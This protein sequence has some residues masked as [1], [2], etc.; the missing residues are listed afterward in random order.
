M[1]KIKSETNVDIVFKSFEQ[2]TTERE[3]GIEGSPEG[4]V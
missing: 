1:E 3:G 2:E 4:E